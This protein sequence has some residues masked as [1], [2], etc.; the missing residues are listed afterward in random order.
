MPNKIN[1]NYLVSSNTKTRPQDSPSDYKKRYLRVR[2]RAKEKLLPFPMLFEGE[3]T[4]ATSSFSKPQSRI[5]G[6]ARWTFPIHIRLLSFEQTWVFFHPTVPLKQ[7]LGLFSYQ[8]SQTIAC[9]RIIWKVCW[10]TDSGS[11]PQSLKFSRSVPG[12]RICIANKFPHD[13]D[14]AGPGTTQRAS[15]FQ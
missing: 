12:L 15:E 7:E 14:S 13:K 1:N 4:L 9:S 11:Y 3:E 6:F 2:I 10:N 5:F 8:S